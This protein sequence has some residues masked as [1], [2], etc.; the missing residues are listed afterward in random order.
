MVGALKYMQTHGGTLLEHGYTHQFG[1]VANPYDGVSANDFEFYRGPR[2]RQRT[3]S[4][5]TAR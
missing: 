1:N 4:S 5:T 3:T 2:R